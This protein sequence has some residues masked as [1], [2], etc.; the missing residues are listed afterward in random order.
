M[1]NK[2]IVS[3]GLDSKLDQTFHYPESKFS[4]SLPVAQNFNGVN[5]LMRDF[6]SFLKVSSLEAR[7]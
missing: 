1:R 5:G 4:E 2:S 3:T 6:T 7:F